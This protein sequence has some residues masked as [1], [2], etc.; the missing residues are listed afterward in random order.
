M[1]KTNHYEKLGELIPSNIKSITYESK[2]SKEYKLFFDSTQE[3]EE[4]VEE[5]E[6]GINNTLSMYS[7]HFQ[8]F[9]LKAINLDSFVNYSFSYIYKSLISLEIILPPPRF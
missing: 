2:S 8:D 9:F 3:N 4:E 5:T 6:F 7:F 1:S